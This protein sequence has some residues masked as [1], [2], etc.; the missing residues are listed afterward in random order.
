MLG[1]GRRFRY[2]RGLTREPAGRDRTALVVRVSIHRAATTDGPLMAHPCA[3]SRIEHVVGGH[4]T[5]AP[6]GQRLSVEVEAIVKGQLRAGCDIACRV[7]DDTKRCLKLVRAGS[8]SHGRSRSDCRGVHVNT[9]ASNCVAAIHLVVEADAVDRDEI[10][11]ENDAQFTT[12]SVSES[13][14][15]VRTLHSSL[16]S[17]RQSRPVPFTGRQ[18]PVVPQSREP[19]SFHSKYVPGSGTTKEE[20]STPGCDAGFL[21]TG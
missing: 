16:I 13:C 2:R 18:L 11:R 4:G 1:H 6:L 15:V 9:A 21:E 20:H 17:R 14:R 19:G 8:G 10:L 12:D 7:G 3:A 5:V